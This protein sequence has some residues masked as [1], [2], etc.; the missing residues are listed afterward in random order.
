[1]FFFRQSPEANCLVCRS[2]RWEDL[3]LPAPLSYFLFGLKRRRVVH[4]EHGGILDLVPEVA[5]SGASG[6]SK[7]HAY[8]AGLP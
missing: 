5:I 8:F 1:L 6:L 7:C 3:L 2:G 4:L